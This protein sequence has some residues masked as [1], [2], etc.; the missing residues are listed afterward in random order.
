MA[1]SRPVVA[2]AVNGCPEIVAEGETGLLVPP[3]QPVAWAQ[4]VARLLDDSE[5]AAVMGRR[6]RQR[7]EE[8]FALSRMIGR[9]EALYER[10][11]C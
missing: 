4:A 2:T 6:G 1:R 10:V 9:I 11:G 7:V 8:C 3:G 5:A